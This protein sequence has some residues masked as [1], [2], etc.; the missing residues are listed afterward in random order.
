MLLTLVL[1]PGMMNAQQ[2][3][4][5]VDADSLQVGD[6]FQYTVLLN[7]NYES[8]DFPAEEDFEEELTLLSMQRYQTPSGTDSLVYNLQFFAVEDI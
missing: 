2:V 8:A 4:T 1:L 3:H 7:G 5:Y 6:T